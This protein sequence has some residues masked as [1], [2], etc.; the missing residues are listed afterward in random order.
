MMQT[1]AHATHVNDLPWS[2]A[3]YVVGYISDTSINLHL[4][5]LNCIEYIV[6]NLLNAK[7]SSKMEH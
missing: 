2:K 4:S 5:P 6:A 7:L 1:A 3:L